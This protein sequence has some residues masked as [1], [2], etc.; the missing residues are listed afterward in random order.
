MWSGVKSDESVGKDAVVRGVIGTINIAEVWRQD[1]SRKYADRGNIEIKG[2]GL[3][4][5]V[6]REPRDQRNF[7][8][9]EPL[10]TDVEKKNRLLWA[11]LKLEWTY[12]DWKL[13]IFSD[14][15][16]FDVCVAAKE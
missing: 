4:R 15:S 14:E 8:K 13:V 16:K 12:N 5:P 6:V 1:R 9:E 3:G 10:L 7:A 2:K 11:K